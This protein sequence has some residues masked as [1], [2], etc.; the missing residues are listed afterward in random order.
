MLITTL[1]LTAQSK[2][3]EVKTDKSSLSWNGYKIVG[4]HSGSINLKSGSLT[5]EGFLLTSAKFIIDM[6][7]ITVTDI[8]G[9]S[10]EKLLNHLKSDDFFNVE[11]HEEASLLIHTASPVNKYQYVL[12]GNLTIKGITKPVKF[13][14][15]LKDQSAVASIRVDRTEYNIKYGSASFFDNLGDKAIKNYFDLE[16]ELVY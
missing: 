2:T 3:V 9:S 8:K 10:A 15:F 11:K 14:A 7:S 1:T 13:E 4:E 5:F 6:S 16:V 12:I